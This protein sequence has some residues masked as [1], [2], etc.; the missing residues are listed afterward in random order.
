MNMN[1][2]LFVSFC[3]WCTPDTK[4]ECQIAVTKFFDKAAN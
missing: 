3:R 1:E 4:N 2:T